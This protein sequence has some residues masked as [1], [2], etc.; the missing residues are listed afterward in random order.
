M[1]KENNAAI[2]QEMKDLYKPEKIKLENGREVVAIPTGIK[3]ESTKKFD[4]EYR[5]APER[6]KGTAKL[7]DIESFIAHVN[8]FK[9]VDSALFACNSTTVPGLTAVLDYHKQTAKG[10]PRFGE[11]RTQY[12]FPVSKE[13]VLWTSKDSVSFGQGEFAA[14][15]EDNILD[16]AY[17]LEDDIEKSDQLMAL[18]TLLGGSFAAPDK[19]V[20]LSKGLAINESSRIKG[21]LDLNTGETSIVYETEHNDEAG[22][23]VKVPNLF[24]IV[25]PVFEDGTRYRVAVRL[26]YR[27]RSGAIAWHYELY[28]PENIFNDAFKD[29]CTKAAKETELPLFVGSPESN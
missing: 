20:A 1:S 16:C 3:L 10:D 7:N 28:Q 19:L 9:D 27:V 15:I 21:K 23:P 2:I 4:D 22:A 12:N 24:L 25:L 26:R 14:F 17:P 8:R 13:W 5:T 29:A 11:H 6:R 18:R